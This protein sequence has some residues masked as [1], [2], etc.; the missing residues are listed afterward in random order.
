MLSYKLVLSEYS[1]NDSSKYPI[2]LKFEHT[3]YTST[4][5]CN[6]L[7]LY[8]SYKCTILT[9]IVSKHSFLY[10]PHKKHKNIYPQNFF[11][12]FFSIFLGK[13]IKIHINQAFNVFIPNTCL[14][15]ATTD[16]ICFHLFE[17]SEP[18]T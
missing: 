9:H 5:F 17:V 4:F 2:E 15:I 11:F 1:R 18:E 7:Y 8:W 6:Y 12:I 13:K 3:F 14:Y 10:F 16:F